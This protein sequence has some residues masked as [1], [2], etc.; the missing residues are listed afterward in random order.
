MLKKIIKPKIINFFE[1]LESLCIKFN[2]FQ[3]VIKE[4]TLLFNTIIN[5]VIGLKSKKLPLK[6]T[7]KTW[8][9]WLGKFNDP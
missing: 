3:E 2:D 4:L 7:K 8:E 5:G 6:K 9:S 1:I